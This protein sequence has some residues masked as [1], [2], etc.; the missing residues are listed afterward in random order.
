MTATLSPLH[1]ATN[2][3]AKPAITIT[4]DEITNAVAGK[5][6]RIFDLA[7]PA[8]PIV[9]MDV[10]EA[11]RSAE[12]SWT[13]TLAADL[14][15]L[16]TYF[17]IVDAGGFAD[18]FGNTFLGITTNSLWRFTIQEE[19]DTQ[20]PAIVIATADLKQTKG[21]AK[22]VDITVTDNKNLP[23]DKT[24]VFYRGIAKL[25]SEP[26]TSATLS[27]VSGGGTISTTFTIEAQDNWYDEMGLEFYFEA[28]DASGNKKRAPAAANTYLYSYVNYPTASSPIL[29]SSR[30]SLGG[31]ANNYRMISVPFE[32]QDK[33]VLTILDEL[34]AADIKKWRLFTY[35]GGD[36][37][38]ENPTDF[39][40]GKG[41]WINVKNSPGEI[42]IDG[43]TTPANNR[44]DFFKMDLAAGWNQIGNP[45]PVEI[46]W[47]EIKTGNASIGK[48]KVFNGS[49]YTDESTL[50]PYQ[51]AFVFVSGSSPVNDL[52]V[53]FKGITTGGRLASKNEGTDLSKPNWI[54]PISAISNE[55]TNSMGGVGMN[56]NANVDWDQFDDINPP[57]FIDYAELAFNK[58]YNSYQFAKDVV[59][60]QDEYV[61]EFSV[62]ASEGQTQLK[63]DNTAITGDKDLILFD[64]DRQKLINM[65][66]LP[67]YSFNAKEGNSF[68]IYFGKDLHDRIKPT[69]VT[70]GNP[71]PNPTNVNS[72]IGFSLPESKSLY[73]VQLE[74]YNSVGQRA[75][76]LVNGDLPAGFYTSTWDIETNK[77]GLYFYRLSVSSKEVRKV[78]TE[79]III[80]R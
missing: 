71:F 10:S 4:F 52:V 19:P 56:E 38:T 1:N 26:F 30:I 16:K 39:I 31:K 36:Q 8:L 50:L 60:A 64:L 53:R 23:V 59:P 51:G 45:Y 78:L 17:V 65:I 18:I 28:E 21:A 34:G 3:V 47:D 63:W 5:K 22:R 13:F 7:Q 46:N 69:A 24:K 68:R 40:R 72:T 55:I 54:V 11:N 29:P 62:N 6:V 35:A 73:N 66:E 37:F 74:V 33:Q 48:L 57:R 76:V 80:N 12:K 44:T 42:K 15:Y 32:L 25:D 41:Y 61:W 14:S 67:S 2:V 70:L 75:A 27:V 58:K 9:I 77:T 79:K 20:A 43:A 49:S